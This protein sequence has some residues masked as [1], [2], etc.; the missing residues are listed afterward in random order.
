MPIEFDVTGTGQERVIVL[1][2]WS[3]CTT[4]YDQCRPYLDEDRFTFAFVDLRGYGRSRDVSGEYSVSEVTSD[5]LAV[6]KQLNWHNFHVIGHSMTGMVAQRIALDAPKQVKSIIAVCPVSAQGMPLDD[7]SWAFFV[8]TT[9]DDNAYKDL[10]RGVCQDSL[11]DGWLNAKTAWNRARSTEASRKGYLTMFSKTN[12]A[13]EAAAIS[14]PVLVIT[15]AADTESL[16]AEAMKSSFLKQ[17]AH[18]ELH[19]IPNCGHY[20]MQECP[21]HFVATIESFL[22]RVAR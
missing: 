4:T 9:H 18:A 6:A 22:G 16:N 19:D 21:P 20:P 11:S 3:C 13:D 2:D 10:M 1:H 7:E 17:H 15:G 8:S 14:Q 12:F 5:I